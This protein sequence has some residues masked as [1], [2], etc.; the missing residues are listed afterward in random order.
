MSP[1][2]QAFGW[3]NHE[4]TRA[5]QARPARSPPSRSMVGRRHRRGSEIRYGSPRRRPQMACESGSRTCRVGRCSTAGRTH[6]Y[7]VRNA[8]GAVRPVGAPLL[9]GKDQI[10]GGPHLSFSGPSLSRALARTRG[11]G[12]ALRE[13][14]GSF[15]ALA[16]SR[17]CCS[18]AVAW[19]FGGERSAGRGG[20]PISGSAA[21]PP[22]F[23]YVRMPLATKSGP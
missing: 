4:N 19:Q 23:A 17:R 2:A 18:P 12:H 9:A 15:G 21:A 13:G 14:G 8:W 16:I 3:A 1:M 6:D 22:L 11:G 10:S 5:L 20:K 7:R